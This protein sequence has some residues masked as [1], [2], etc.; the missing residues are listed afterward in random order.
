MLA[1]SVCVLSCAAMAAAVAPLL[2]ISQLSYEFLGGLWRPKIRI[3]P[4]TGKCWCPMHG[5]ALW[6]WGSP[7][8]LKTNATWFFPRVCKQIH[9]KVTRR[10]NLRETRGVFCREV[11]ARDFGKVS[12]LRGFRHN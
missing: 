2:R 12:V 7:I 4:V 8:V 3:E 9:L 10:T 5:A 11:A 1:C 6:S